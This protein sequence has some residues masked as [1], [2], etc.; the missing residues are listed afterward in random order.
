MDLKPWLGAISILQWD[1]DLADYRYRLFGTK[2]I[3]WLGRNLTGQAPTAWL[4]D[5]SEEIRL[6]LDGVA[7]RHTPVG[8]RL[9]VSEHADAWAKRELVPYEQVLWPLSYGPRA[10]PAVIVLAVR[11]SDDAGPSTRC[12]HADGLPAGDWFS[13]EPPLSHGE[14]SRLGRRGRTPYKLRAPRG[15]NFSPH[16]Q[17]APGPRASLARSLRHPPSTPGPAMNLTDADKRKLRDAFAIR[18]SVSGN[19]MNLIGLDE[20]RA[21]FPTMWERHRDRIRATTEAILKQHTDPQ[22][23]IVLPVG[24]ANFVV[25][26]TRLDP[27]AAQLRAS[28][29]KAE[30]LRRFMGDDAL[31]GLDMRIRGL[32]LDSSAVAGG[33]LTE[34]LAS[35][36]EGERSTGS[37]PKAR[38]GTVMAKARGPASDG[39]GT[40]FEQTIDALETRFR[41]SFDDLDFGFVPYRFEARGVFAVF[42]CRPVRYSAMGD[43]LTGYSVLPPDAD[44]GQFATLDRLL[45]TRVRQGLVDMAL[46]KRMALVGLPVSFETM[47]NRGI[48]AEYLALLQKIPSDLRTYLVPALCRCPVGVPQGRLAE[49]LNPLLRFSRGVNIRLE[50][51]KQALAQVK[52]AGRCP[53][54]STSRMPPI[55]RWRHRP[56]STAMRRPR[57]SSGC[58]VSSTA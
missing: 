25:L 24:D 51:P 47:T 50:S 37:T 20:V 15:A 58:G 27:Q 1:A 26:F 29:I 38:P 14:P 54:A 39:A 41:F 49:I 36:T 3:A 30:V 6:R 28:I 18:A 17:S 2:W 9:V 48:A 42:A 35:A 52:A 10:G 7:A 43:I 40:R 46:R 57:G 31:A 56:F 13:A 5:T 21:R 32:E 11:V 4:D 44:A 45:L 33:A 22:T 12:L 16:E 8:G 53:S 55:L 23:D 34:L 19:L